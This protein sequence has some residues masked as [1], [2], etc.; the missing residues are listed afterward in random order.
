PGHRRAHPLR[1]RGLDR[2]PAGGRTGRVTRF[3]QVFREES[4][5]VVAT[6]IRATGDFDLAEDAVQDA[7]AIALERSPVDGVPATPGVWLTTTARNRAIDRLRRERR[8][9][10]KQAAL[11]SLAAMA[12]TDPEEDPM[13]SLPDE[14]LSLVF[15]CCHPALALEAQVALTLRLLGGL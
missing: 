5:R 13:P 3:E 8:L 6:L 14:R 1:A 4:G 11:A 10:E 12:P 15:T 2:G 7:F 9:G